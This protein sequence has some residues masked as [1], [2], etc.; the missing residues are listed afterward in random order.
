MQ[1]RFLEVALFDHNLH[2]LSVSSFSATDTGLTL[3]DYL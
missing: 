1:I 2:V 3:P